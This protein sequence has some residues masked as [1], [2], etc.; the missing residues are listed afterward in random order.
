MRAFLVER[1]YDSMITTRGCL[2]AF[3]KGEDPSSKVNAWLEANPDAR[4]IDV[5]VFLMD[6]F[7]DY[8]SYVLMILEL[9]DENKQEE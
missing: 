8:D 5:K 2:S 1:K 7:I 9:P 3:R 6:R 4:L